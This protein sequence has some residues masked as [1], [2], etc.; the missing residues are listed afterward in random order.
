ME[1]TILNVAALIAWVV[2][3]F[4]AFVAV[5]ADRVQEQRQVAVRS[6]A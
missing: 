2:I 3:G 5:W 6:F 1:F 4:M